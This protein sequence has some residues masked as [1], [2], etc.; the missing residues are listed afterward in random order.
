[1]LILTL[2]N[3]N[4]LEGLIKNLDIIQNKL[5]IIAGDFNIYF[6]SNLETKGGKPLLIR[7]SMA[8]L[9]EMRES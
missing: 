3:L 2:N 5:I 9:V 8:K 7:K 1:M 4:I 6:N